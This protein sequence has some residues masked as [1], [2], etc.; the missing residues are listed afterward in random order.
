MAA[1]ER[2]WPHF[3]RIVDVCG[4]LVGAGAATTARSGAKPS[5]RAGEP[6]ALTETTCQPEP[7]RPLAG[8][9]VGIG[10]K[11]DDL[12]FPHGDDK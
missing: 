3:S 7:S 9:F 11:P 1:Q 2:L 5:T 6:T 8:M 10:S 4:L 12:Y